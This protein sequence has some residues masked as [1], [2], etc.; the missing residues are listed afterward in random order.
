MSDTVTALDSVDE[1]LKLGQEY[2]CS[3]VHLAVNSPPIWRRNGTLQPIW[4]N[5][6]LLTAADCERLAKGFLEESEAERLEETGDVDFCYSPEFGRF[7][8]SVVK[9]RLGYDM[10]F[11]IISPKIRTM[12]ELG[13]PRNVIKPITQY[14]YGL[15][16]VTGAVGSGKSTTL[17]TLINEINHERDRPYHYVGR[18][19]RVRL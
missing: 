8:S 13:I 10:A 14:Q 16:M 3:D 5:A 1:Y 19:H 2:E 18:P 7:R 17:A 11:R 6:E 4:D 12:E 15:I 9:Q